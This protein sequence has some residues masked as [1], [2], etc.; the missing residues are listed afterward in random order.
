M[1]ELYRRYRPQKFSEIVGQ[2]ETIKTLADKIAKR[3]LPHAILLTGNSGLGKTTIAR[4]IARKLGC[5]GRDLTELNC[6]DSR[7]IEMMRDIRSR[8]GLAPTSGPCRCWILDECAR[9]TSDSQSLALKV[10]EDPPNHAYFF[11]CTTDPHKLLPTIRS[12]CTTFALAPL[13]VQDQEKV[14][15]SVC[16]KAG[17]E[18]AD[19]VRER[20]IEVAEGS[21]RKALVLLDQISGLPT[22]R[23]QL[24][25]VRKSD[26]LKTAIDLAR[27]AFGRDARKKWPQ[28]A[29][30]IGD[31]KKSGEEPEGIRRMLLSYSEKLL[32]NGSGAAGRAANVID[33]LE[34]NVYDSGWPGLSKALYGIFH[35]D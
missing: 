4:I 35:D 17:L 9:M 23:E 7:G 22:E 13:S 31:L 10:L 25:A 26:A 24:E 18:I 6:A 12:R 33:A 21:A 32:L 8:M 30:M 20:I 16:E 3:N 27:L 34:C 14:I 2:D 28:A 5:R 11:L 19:S 1:N 29:A 15:A